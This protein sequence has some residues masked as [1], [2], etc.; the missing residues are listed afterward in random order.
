MIFDL[1]DLI[2][3]LRKSYGEF[4]DR[5]LMGQSEMD[6]Q[7]RQLVNT[8]CGVLIALILLAAGIWGYWVLWAK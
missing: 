5:S 2:E 1:V 4:Q 3:A 6:R 8:V 7:S